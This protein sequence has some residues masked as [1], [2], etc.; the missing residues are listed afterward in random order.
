LGPATVCRRYQKADMRGD[1]LEEDFYNPGLFLSRLRKSAKAKRAMLNALK[2]L[3]EGLTDF[4]LD[5]RGGSVQVIFHE[6][7]FEIP[8][9]RLSDGT[10]RY[11]FLVAVLCDPEPPPL[12]CIEEPELGLHPDILAKLADLLVA[13]SER[14]QIIVTTHSDI[15]MD[16]MTERPEVV[17]VCEKHGG[18]TEMRRL[19]RKDLAVWL[20]HYRLGQLW[21]KGE[22]GGTRW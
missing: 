11:L 1:R 13:A 2:D 21:T 9:T 6:G 14:T 7:D 18:R 12:I 19:R 10:L 17:V 5:A 8:A 20:K 22:L 3:Y 16:A 4:D 15:L